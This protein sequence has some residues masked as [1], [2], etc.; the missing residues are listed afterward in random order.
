MFSA[1]LLDHFQNPRHSGVLPPPAVTVKV[2]NP[3]CGDMLV[4]SAEVEHGIVRRAGFQVK[5]CTASI[6]AGSAV[7]ELIT[8]LPAADLGSIDAAA[9]E[10][11]LDG[12]P[13]SSRHAAALGAEG[14]RALARMIATAS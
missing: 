11:A 12:L 5:G 7:A 8:G 6:A 4:L 10:A 13:P 1:K 9:V 14:V 2:E 3:A